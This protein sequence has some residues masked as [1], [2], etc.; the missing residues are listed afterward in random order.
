[1]SQSFSAPTTKNQMIINDFIDNKEYSD[2]I[3]ARKC[4]GWYRKLIIWGGAF[5]FMHK[6]CFDPFLLSN[7]QN[8]RNLR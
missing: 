7:R 3:C 6:K 4:A 2:I 8:L 5:S 1:M